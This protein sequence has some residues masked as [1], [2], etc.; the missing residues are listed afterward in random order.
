MLEFPGTDGVLFDLGNTL[1]PFTPKD[2]MEFVVKW[3]HSSGLEGSDLPFR[4]FLDSFRRTVKKERRRMVQ[5]KWE[6]SV[7]YRSRSIVEDLGEIGFDIRGKEKELERTHTPAFSSCLW[8]SRDSINVLKGIRSARGSG[9]D[10][11]KT[12]LISNAGDHE[13]IRAFLKENDLTEY[14]DDIVISSELGYAKPWKDI[15]Q[16]PV[17]RLKLDP[18]RSVYIGDRYKIDFLASME[19]GLKPIYIRQYHTSGEPPEGAGPIEPT[20]THILDL[21]PLLENGY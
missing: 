19:A 5:E 1:I 3:Y 8:I 21:I 18:G 2:S 12:A 4:E 14:F 11:V 20:I 13:A 10:P 17:S 7:S 16:G 6:T 15:F 9:G